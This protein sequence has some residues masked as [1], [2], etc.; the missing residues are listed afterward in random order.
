MYPTQMP[1]GRIFFV[2]AGEDQNRYTEIFEIEKRSFKLELRGRSNS[3]CFYK[4][5]VAASLNG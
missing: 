1:N 4:G 2:I 3:H 5:A